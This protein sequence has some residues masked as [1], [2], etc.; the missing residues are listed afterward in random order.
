MTSSMIGDED[1]IPASFFFLSHLM[2]NAKADVFH[3]SASRS[4][5]K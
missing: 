3:C 5:M 4:R 1:V 2:K